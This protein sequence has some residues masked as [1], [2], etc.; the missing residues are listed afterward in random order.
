MLNFFGYKFA[1]RYKDVYSKISKSL[2]GFN[3]PSHYSDVIIKP[4]RKINSDLIVEEWDNIQR[5]KILTY[6]F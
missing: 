6:L 4:V 3:H 2:Y 5:T 1:P